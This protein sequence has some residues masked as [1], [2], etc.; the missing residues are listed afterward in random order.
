MASRRAAAASASSSSVGLSSS[1]SSSSAVEGALRAALGRVNAANAVA[2]EEGEDTRIRPLEDP[3]LVGEEAAARARNERLARKHGE[4]VLIR[5]DRRWD[6]W[7]GMFTLF[8]MS[9][10]F[11]LLLTLFF[12]YYLFLPL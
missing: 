4:D 8:L 1:S 2:S 12:R 6:W 9:T 11:P 3:Y 7:L 10:T 5:E